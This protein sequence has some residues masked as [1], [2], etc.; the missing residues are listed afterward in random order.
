MKT[1]FVI[2]VSL[3]LTACAVP[4]PAKSPFQMSVTDFSGNTRQYYLEGEFINLHVFWDKRHDAGKPIDCAFSNAFSGEIVWRG[5]MI[6][7]DLQQSQSQAVVT[8]NP[9]YPETGLKPAP[10]SYTAVC[11]FNN[12][13]KAQISFNVVSGK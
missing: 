7:P 12:E 11:N 9:P 5:M 1:T 10:G 8:W 4:P 6:I 13:G 3:L 2:I